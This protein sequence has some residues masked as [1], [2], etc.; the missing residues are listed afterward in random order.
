MRKMNESNFKEVSFVNYGNQINKRGQVTIFIIVA[1]LIVG[2]IIGYFFLRGSFIGESIPQELEPAYDY[3]IS[4]L[5][6]TAEEG[7]HLLGEQGGYIEV[8]TFEPGSAYMPFSSQLDFLGQPVPYWMYVSGN[9]LLKEQIPTKSSMATELEKYVEE[10][11]E[12]CDFTEFELMGYDVYVDAGSVEVDINKMDV[13]LKV[14]SK[15][16]LFKGEQS[17]VI[18][19]HKFAVD[20]KLGKF[21]DMAIDVYNFEK[22]DMFLE[23]YAIDVMRLYAPNTGTD[24]SCAPKIF[25]DEE[26]REN[27][28][29]G[30]ASN[31][32]SIK[33]DGS[34]YDLS[35]EER[36]YFVTDI[37]SKID[38]NMN[39]LYSPDWPTRIEIYGDRVAK[40]IG[41]Q[42]GMSLMGF[43][44]VPYHLVYD[45]NFPV[46]I[47]FYDSEEI[48]QFPV[49]VVISK[50]QAREA[51]PSTLWASIESRVCEFSNQQID[52]YTYDID[53]NPVEARVQ[54][55]CLDAVCEIGETK[56]EGNDAVY[57]GGVQ[58][59]VNGYILATAEGYSDGKYQIS[60]NE[61]SIANIVLNK[62]YDVQLDLGNVEK[63]LVN[64]VS[65][66]YS[67]TA[68]YPEI[69]SVELVE[70]Y[71]NVSV[72][73]YDSSSLFFP[74][75]SRRE[76]VDVPK[77]GLAGLFGG[78][79]EKCYEI[80]MPS[81]SVDFAV[82]GGGKTREYLT[83]DQLANAN[84]LNI[85]VPLF[86]LPQDLDGLQTNH[87]RVD[88]EVVYLEFE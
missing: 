18:S 42:P 84:E 30:L 48:F 56:I 81:M 57:H 86:G 87:I 77:S 60:T 82:V 33:L 70:A 76:C 13:E 39:F 17:A 50:S 3:Y 78:E 44:Y 74:A 23:K 85:N 51:L 27:I 4:C 15:V 34:Y 28:V 79:D 6:S 16:T 31:I 52:V 72:Y 32:P 38:E 12:D 36:E 75:T 43:C 83:S 1:I 65:D 25:V 46:L 66:D 37:G 40:P 10:R 11:I 54:F 49:S 14:K 29:A 62:K 35:S 73:V 69:K 5:A 2:A 58:Q 53:L 55:K 61:E 88:D 41:L 71:Y 47:Q 59:C 21:Y 8:P 45:I 22:A 9:N 68:L 20:S 63:A 64:F 7:I 19:N 80:N 26:I 67:A 24:I